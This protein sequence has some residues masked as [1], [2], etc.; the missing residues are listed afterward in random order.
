MVYDQREETKMRR[1]GRN[2]S[3]SSKER[4]QANTASGKKTSNLKLNNGRQRERN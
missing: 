2:N 4:L 3:P 1:L